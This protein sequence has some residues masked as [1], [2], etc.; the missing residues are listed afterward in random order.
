MAQIVKHDFVS[1]SKL[2]V[3]DIAYQFTIARGAIPVNSTYDAVTLKNKIIL[4]IPSFVFN[5]VK[6]ISFVLTYPYL[7]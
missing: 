4:K 5:T 2:P 1:P 3:T 7:L 6:L